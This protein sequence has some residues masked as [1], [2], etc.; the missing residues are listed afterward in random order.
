MVGSK[1]TLDGKV[2]VFGGRMGGDSFKSTIYTSFYGFLIDRAHP[3]LVRNFVPNCRRAEKIR[4]P[5]RPHA[6]TSIIGA[7]SGVHHDAG[8]PRP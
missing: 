1:L 3:N 5:D 4:I 2:F 6:K 8:R 7:D